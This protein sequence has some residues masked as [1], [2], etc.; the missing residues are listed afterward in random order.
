L[1]ENSHAR[2]RVM[3]TSSSVVIARK[4]VCRTESLELKN[5]DTQRTETGKEG[6]LNKDRRIVNNIWLCT[7]GELNLHQ[8]T[9]NK[10]NNQENKI[11]R[12]ATKILNTV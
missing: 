9:L 4:C 8:A 10:K 7:A 3:M 5:R 1:Q 2:P 6:I 12:N 11:D